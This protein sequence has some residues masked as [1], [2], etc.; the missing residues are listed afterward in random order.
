MSSDEL[1]DLLSF[2]PASLREVETVIGLAATLKLVEAFGGGNCYIPA[3]SDP[4]A[5]LVQVLGER[6]VAAMIEQYGPGSFAV[7]AL[8]AVR[9]KRVLI[10]RLSGSARDVARKLGVTDRWVRYVRAD[11]RSETDSRQIDMFQT[12]E[13]GSGSASD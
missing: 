8:A 10:S 1:D 5:H 11:T 3:T 2:W 4:S 6:A 7:P 12:N 9:H 13:R